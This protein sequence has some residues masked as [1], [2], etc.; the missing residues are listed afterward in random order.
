M[1][2]LLAAAITLYA[3]PMVLGLSTVDGS[4]RAQL[5]RWV[6]VLAIVAVC[7]AAHFVAHYVSLGFLG[8]VEVS[9]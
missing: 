2:R 9:A 1:P 4:R 3:F 6:G 7:V 8:V 5:A